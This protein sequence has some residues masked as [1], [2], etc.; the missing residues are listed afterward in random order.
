MDTPKLGIS[1][2]G[3][4]QYCGLLRA[5]QN[6]ML[7]RG[8]RHKLGPGSGA[9]GIPTSPKRRY[10]ISYLRMSPLGSGGSSQRRRTLLLLAV[11][12]S[13]FP[14]I[15]SASP[16]GEGIRQLEARGGSTGRFEKAGIMGPGRG[17]QSKAMMVAGGQTASWSTDW[18]GFLGLAGEG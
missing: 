8:W 15:P 1:Q 16:A 17:R 9:P 2:A 18:I 6:S 12:H 5:T 14:G 3:H 7:G 11:S 13:T 4:T 10:L